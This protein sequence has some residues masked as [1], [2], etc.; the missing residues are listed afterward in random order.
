MPDGVFRA[1]KNALG[2][3]FEPHPPP[4]QGDVDGL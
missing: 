2:A 3:V 1:P 4:T